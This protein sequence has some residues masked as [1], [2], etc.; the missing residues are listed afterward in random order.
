[1]SA[2]GQ[3]TETICLPGH[4]L[5]LTELL[6]VLDVLRRRLARRTRGREGAFAGFDML[7]VARWRDGAESVPVLFRATA[8]SGDRASQVV[9]YAATACIHVH[10]VCRGTGAG[11]AFVVASGRTV[12]LADRFVAPS[13]NR[14]A[15]ASPTR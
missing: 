3:A 9:Q 1:M 14:F 11:D 8:V 5:T 12:G 15:I 13:A 2:D 7:D 10:G 6:R 4:G